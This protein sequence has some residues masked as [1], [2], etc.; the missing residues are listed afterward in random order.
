MTGERVDEALAGAYW[1]LEIASR[2]AASGTPQ[3]GLDLLRRNYVRDAV[4]NPE[5]MRQIRELLPDGTPPAERGRASD[6]ASQTTEAPD[7]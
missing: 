5:A 7:A 3:D 2:L 4:A 1:D 6:D